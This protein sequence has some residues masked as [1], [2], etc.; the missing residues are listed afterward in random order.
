MSFKIVFFLFLCS[1]TENS[2][3]HMLK[4]P[5]DR[6]NDSAYVIIDRTTIDKQENTFDLVLVFKTDTNRYEIYRE[7][8]QD[9]SVEFKQVS[10]YNRGDLY[11]ELFNI[12]DLPTGRSKD[13]IRDKHS[14]TFYLTDW[15]DNQAVGDTLI[16]SSINF[17]NYRIKVKSMLPNSSD[18]EIQ[19]KKIWDTV[20]FGRVGS[21]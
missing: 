12:A 10:S 7:K 17:T 6:R 5:I 20:Q 9:Y 8:N 14:N 11:Y 2:T 15:Y 1:C 4:N 16:K 3:S 21:K 19:L 13:V 18:Y